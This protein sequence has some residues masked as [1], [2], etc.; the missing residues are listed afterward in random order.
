[1][2]IAE[3][4]QWMRDTPAGQLASALGRDPFARDVAFVERQLADTRQVYRER[5]GRELTDREAEV[6][7]QGA[8]LRAMPEAAMRQV[9]ETVPAIVEMV[10][11]RNV[12]AG[13]SWSPSFRRGEGYAMRGPDG[14][15]TGDP[16]VAAAAEAGEEARRLAAEQDYEA[17]RNG[18]LVLRTIARPS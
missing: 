17:W 1:M 3:R 16:A 12:A 5:F 15:W 8:E 6:V 7:R 9:P 14:T 13:W 10:N 2:S 18:P 11:S 4:R